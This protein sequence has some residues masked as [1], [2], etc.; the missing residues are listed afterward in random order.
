[1]R[2][3]HNCMAHFLC[4]KEGDSVGLIRCNLVANQVAN[5]VAIKLQSSKETL[6]KTAFAVFF[7][8]KNQLWIK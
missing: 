2:H 4:P 1:M 8:S 7:V 3:A 5:Q 6:E